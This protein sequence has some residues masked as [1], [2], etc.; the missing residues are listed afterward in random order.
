[1]AHPDAHL[2]SPHSRPPRHTPPAKLAIAATVAAATLLAACGKGTPGGGMPH[3]PVPVAAITVQA[4]SLPVSFE[5]PA[6]TLG[7]RE[8]EVR[9]RVTG[10]LEKR[11]YTEGSRV[12][13]GQSLFTIDPAPFAATLARA[14]ADVAAAEARYE[15]AQ[16]DAARLKPLIA[17][18]AVSQKEFDDAHSSE[19]IGRADLLA[20]RAEGNDRSTEVRPL[21]ARKAQRAGPAR[22]FTLA[23]PADPRVDVGRVHSCGQHAHQ[24]LA[25]PGVRHGNILAPDQRLWPAMADQL[26]AG[27]GGGKAHARILSFCGSQTAPSPITSAG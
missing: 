23:V 10:I 18:K 25:R 14:E 21:D 17:A 27:H 8:I 15:Q 20:A 2:S 19:A 13:A 5:Y 7:V 16:R 1:M 24:N 26:D 3:G 22:L 9:A 12:K 4:E 11:N 6:Q